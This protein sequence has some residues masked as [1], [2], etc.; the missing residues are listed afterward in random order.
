MAVVNPERHRF[1]TEMYSYT[2]TTPKSDEQVLASFTRGFF[3]GPILFP[4]RTILRYVLHGRG[5]ITA[6]SKLSKVD[7]AT[8]KILGPGPM[9]LFEEDSSDVKKIWRASEIP[10]QSVLPVGSYLYGAFQV[11][12]VEFSGESA[13]SHIDFGFGSDVNKF[14]GFH[15]FLVQRLA[16]NRVTVSFRGVVC[17]PTKDTGSP[18]AFLR[19]L[20][21]IYAKL[22]FNDAIRAIQK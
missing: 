1:D 14:A 3:G 9:A 19:P 21:L 7:L 11:T 16:D 10:T 2:L 20:H 8:K 22:L 13:E 6:F 12:D 4:E 17:N 18:V 5:Q 15:R